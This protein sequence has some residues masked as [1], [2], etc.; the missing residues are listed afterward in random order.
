MKLFKYVFVVCLLVLTFGCT[1][2]NVPPS[3]SSSLSYKAYKHMETINLRDV[4][5]ALILDE[6]LIKTKSD[7]TIKSG[8][9]E[10]EGDFEFDIGRAFAVK[11]IK[12]LS[13]QF[14]TISLVEE[15]ND[16]T[17]RDFDAVMRICIQD[18]DTSMEIEQGFSNV[19]TKSYIRLN[20]RAEIKDLEGQKVVWVGT[21]EV[22]QTGGMTEKGMTYQ[23]TGRVLSTSLDQAI[24]I[25]IGDLLKEMQKSQNLNKYF[26][27]WENS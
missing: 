3:L 22:D 12:A 23:G 16:L 18:V 20:I 9:Y 6:N 17:P 10:F 24:D 7:Q 2:T 25:A 1:K 21:S 26:T 11:F 27:R 19:S 4:S 8:K 14:K 5:V 13:H 15:D